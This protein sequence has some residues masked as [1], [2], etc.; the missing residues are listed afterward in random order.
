[1]ALVQNILRNLKG[2]VFVSVL[3]FFYVAKVISETKNIS[4]KHSIEIVFFFCELY[5]SLYF[6]QTYPIHIHVPITFIFTLE[7]K[8][9]ILCF[10]G[11]Q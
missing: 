4:S 11:K 8:L 2:K 1:M 7:K 9:A 3:L 6:V 10:D 5:N